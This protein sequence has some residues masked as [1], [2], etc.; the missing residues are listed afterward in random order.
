M[1]IHMVGFAWR[2]GRCGRCWCLG[3]Q[4]WPG[5]RCAC[6]CATTSKLDRGDVNLVK[7]IG[8][9]TRRCV[10][11]RGVTCRAVTWWRVLLFC[12][13]SRHTSRH[14]CG[15]AYRWVCTEAMTTSLKNIGSAATLVGRCGGNVE[16]TTIKTE[17]V[18]TSL[19]NPHLPG[20]A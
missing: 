13:T 11:C 3:R 14:A 9:A 15:F 6:L 20:T 12:V 17:E 1:F 19:K 18:I 2:R 7:N 10:A 5:R 8:A 4:P 16:Y